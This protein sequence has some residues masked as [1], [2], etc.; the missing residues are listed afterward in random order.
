MCVQLC[1][2]TCPQ[3][4]LNVCSSWTTLA[5]IFIV[6]QS[7]WEMKRFVLSTKVFLGSHKGVMISDR[8][9]GICEELQIPSNDHA[10]A[11]DEA[12]NTQLSVGILKHMTGQFESVSCKCNSVMLE[13]WPIN[14]CKLVGLFKHSALATNEL[15][16]KA[17]RNESD[18]KKLVQHCATRIQHYASRID[19]DEYNGSV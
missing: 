14:R 15:K 3:H 12:A 4:M 18:E 6:I 11:H 7:S 2:L 1:P 17:V 5:A 16:K 19:I 8:I 13:K 10:V 9:M